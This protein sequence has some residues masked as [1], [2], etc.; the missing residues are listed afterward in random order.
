MASRR[1][2]LRPWGPTLPIL[3]LLVFAGAFAWDG[4]RARRAHREAAEGTVRD[5]AGF[6]AAVAAANVAA[7][8]ER[9]LLF[10]FYEADLAERRGSVEPVSPEALASNPPESGRCADL[11]PDGRW[12]AR[13]GTEGPLEAAGQIEPA[14][15]G[16]LTDTLRAVLR[17]APS[18]SP[19]GNLFPPS[20]E[21]ARLV[22]YR[23]RRDSARVPLEVHALAHC[24]ADRDG[25]LFSSAGEGAPLLP[26]GLVGRA[27]VDSLLAV[28]VADPAGGILYR[29]DGPGG[30]PYVG[31]W[32]GGAAGSLAGLT[33]TV[34]LR[35]ETAD[36]LVA[37]GLPATRTSS[38]L[39]L[40]F[41]T[42]LLAG[43]TLYQWRRSLALVAAR[44]RFVADVSHELRT[45]LQQ[46]LLFVQLHRMGRLRD[47]VEKEHSLA[48]V[49]RETRRLIDLVDRIL[50]FAGPG[51][52]SAPERCSLTDVSRQTVGDFEP[53]AAGREVGIDVSLEEDP[54]EVE[55]APGSIRQIL[56][57][58]LDNAVKHGPPGQRLRVSVE[59]RGERAVL[60]V[61]DEGPGIPA[62]ERRRVQE[63]FHRLARE[64]RTGSGGS[65]IG[66]AVV[67][68][69]VEAAGGS[70]WLE[71][72]PGGGLRARVELP[73]A[74]HP[75]GARTPSPVAVP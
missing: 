73:R 72:A 53:L 26:P 31:S 1:T 17:R 41:M 50:L 75:A 29:S 59:A 62:G 18:S 28:A 2:S 30:S 70:L 45:P 16:W 23:V 40:V 71:E 67:R 36:R 64:E 43:A 56:L 69:L 11:Y 5:W 25:P 39:L 32:R 47:D 34:E 48:I 21:P 49:E 46:I 37:G 8:M 12:F 6:A 14:L 9:T 52:G 42:L 54:L 61:D 33:V 58:L 27:P 3:V 20:G 74:E 60:T 66:L 24:L 15:A 63:P 57:N 51:G 19:Y 68:D 35:A 22:A 10:A 13:L 38:R 65:G 44:E 7:R 55:A 4:V